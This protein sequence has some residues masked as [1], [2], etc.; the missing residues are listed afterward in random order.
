MDP[1]SLM[2]EFE[3][4]RWHTEFRGCKSILEILKL[5]NQ[6]QLTF[7][8]PNV[9]CL[10]KLCL[11]LPVTTA[12]TE[13]SF[14]KLKIVKTAMRSTMIEDRLSALLVL[15]T[16]RDLK[17]KVNFDQVFDAFALSRPRCLAFWFQ[18]LFFIIIIIQSNALFLY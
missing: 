10:Y 2:A 17:D 3:L 16:E 14:S 8:Y 13:R 4:F 1:V 9:T 18:R 5:L 7:A 11:T 15:S 12:T 6:K